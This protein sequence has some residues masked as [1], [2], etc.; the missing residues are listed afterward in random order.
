MIAADEVAEMLGIS[1]GAVYDLAAPK[2]PIPCVRFGRRCIRFNRQDIQA[3]IEACRQTQVQMPS[4][5]GAAFGRPTVKLKV[6]DPEK[7]IQEYRMKTK[8]K[9]KPKR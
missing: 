1:R 6:S 2:G 4:M 3:H 5:R 7:F 8:T 9:T